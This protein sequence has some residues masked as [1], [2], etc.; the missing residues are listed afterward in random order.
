MT[1]EL[2]QKH[3]T[4]VSYLGPQATVSS[5]LQV[6]NHVGAQREARLHGMRR[7]AQLQGIRCNPSG[8]GANLRSLT[9]RQPCIQDCT[10][11]L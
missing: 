4:A 10:P 1:L 6:V 3:A 5:V 11:P 2:R 7:E 8:D 9:M